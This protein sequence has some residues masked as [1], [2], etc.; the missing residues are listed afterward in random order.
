MT[1][2]VFDVWF[3]S[4]LEKSLSIA[5]CIA[6]QLKKINTGKHENMGVGKGQGWYI[7]V[8]LRRV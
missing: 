3:A 7:N 2:L 1:I 5:F 8:S 6:H 4:Y